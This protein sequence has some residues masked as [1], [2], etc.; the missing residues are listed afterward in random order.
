MGRSIPVFCAAEGCTEVRSVV[1]DKHGVTFDIQ[2]MFSR[3]LKSPNP[4][5]RL[6]YWTWGSCSAACVMYRLG[7]A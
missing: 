1:D 2:K 7:A 4:E 3:D 5:V 6:W